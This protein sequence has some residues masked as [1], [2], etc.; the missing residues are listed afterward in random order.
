MFKTCRQVND[1]SSLIRERHNFHDP[2]LRRKNI[3]DRK[4]HFASDCI[5]LM[6]IILQFHLVTIAIK[7]AASERAYFPSKL[8]HE[9]RNKT[10]CNRHDEVLGR[11]DWIFTVYHT[12]DLF[13]HFISA[14]PK[15]ILCITLINYWKT[16]L[17]LM[18]WFITWDKKKEGSST[19]LSFVQ[20][21]Y[22]VRK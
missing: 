12:G 6:Y 15:R 20:N 1:Q 7:L 21:Y 10:P 13:E 14:T 5:P 3:P 4:I 9:L 18:N 17:C 22:W 19:R 2:F 16:I 11:Y 8:Q